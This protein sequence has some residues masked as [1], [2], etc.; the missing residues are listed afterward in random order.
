M[1]L[2]ILKDKIETIENNKHLKEIFK[3]IFESDEPYKYNQNGVFI[4]MEKLKPETI[5]KIDEYINSIYKKTIKVNEAKQ[6]LKHSNIKKFILP[7][8]EQQLL[9][10]INIYDLFNE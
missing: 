5:N 4:P 9:K 8:H 6:N 10:K 1:N 3:L 2:E 7:K